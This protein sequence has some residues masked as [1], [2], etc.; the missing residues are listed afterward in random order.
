M[1]FATHVLTT[2]A[3]IHFL[4]NYIHDV[5]IYMNMMWKETFYI[6]DGLIKV[7]MSLNA[8]REKMECDFHTHIIILY[9]MAKSYEIW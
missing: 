8:G 3:S 1:K 7:I 5:T 6:S 4:D 2:Q 9:N